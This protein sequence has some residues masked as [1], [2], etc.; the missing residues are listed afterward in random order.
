M[1][2]GGSTQW[3]WAGWRMGAEQPTL[4]MACPLPTRPPRQTFSQTGRSQRSC[5]SGRET[6]YS[7]CL[8]IQPLPPPLQPHPASLLEPRL[9]A[10]LIELLSFAKCARLSVASRP[11]H[12]LLS[13][14]WLPLL[15]SPPIHPA[16]IGK[17]LLNHKN[18][19]ILHVLSTYSV[20]SASK[21]LSDLIFTTT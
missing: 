16:S 8:R 11:L 20:L 13:L 14:P 6:H 12:M 5:L 17:C 3:H 7:Q 10:R 18:N 9:C 21:M 19:S 4:P 15:P 2:A 1:T